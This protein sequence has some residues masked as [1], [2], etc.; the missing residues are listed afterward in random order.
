MTLYKTRTDL[1]ADLKTEEEIIIELM[2]Q[3]PKITIP[4]IASQ[5]NKGLTTTK[6]KIK[7]LRESAKIKRQGSLKGGLWKVVEK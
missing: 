4:E 3:N 6:E 7:K 2:K 1:K 5:I